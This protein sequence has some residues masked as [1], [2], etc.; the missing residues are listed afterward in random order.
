M[1]FVLKPAMCRAMKIIFNTRNIS[2][3]TYSYHDNNI[4]NDNNNNNN[5][6]N[7]SDE[8]ILKMMITTKLIRSVQTLMTKVFL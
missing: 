1:E 6:N 8:I 7:N 5:N 3:Y 4:D 2:R